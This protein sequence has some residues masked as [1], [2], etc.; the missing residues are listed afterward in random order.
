[1]KHSS[2]TDEHCV[3]VPFISNVSL[4]SSPGETNRILDEYEKTG[5]VPQDFSESLP[6]LAER[7]GCTVEEIRAAALGDVLRKEN[8]AI[9]PRLKVSGDG[10][11]VFAQNEEARHGP[12]SDDSPGEDSSLRGDAPEQFAFIPVGQEITL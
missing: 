4:V 6:S 9:I 11:L 8:A 12:P 1:M 2:N 10:L 7:A 3:R 5:V